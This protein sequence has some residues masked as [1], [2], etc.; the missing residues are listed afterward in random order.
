MG[1]GGTRI[2]GIALA[3]CVT[4]PVVGEWELEAT[5]SLGRRQRRSC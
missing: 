4:S 2:A 3:S 5:F 1:L